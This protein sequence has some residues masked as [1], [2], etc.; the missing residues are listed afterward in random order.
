MPAA[1]TSPLVVV[2]GAGPAGAAAAHATASRGIRTILLERARHPREKVCGEGCTPRAVRNLER[3]G[4]LGSLES[5]GAQVSHAF[6]V[7]PG[8]IELHTPLPAR[9]HGGKALVVPRA[10]LDARLVDRAVRSGAELREQVRVES[11]QSHD[12]GIRVLCRGH[13]PIDADVVI[14]CDG[15]P[16]VV[17]KSLGAAAFSPRQH[18]FA[19]RG[20]F[21]NVDLRHPEAL[22]I[23]WDRRVLPAYGWVFPLPGGRANV[24]IGLRTDKLR[25]HDAGLP[26]IFDR[27]LDSPRLRTMLRH[28]RINGRAKGHGLPMTS[29]WGRVV[30]DRAILAG[31]AAGFVNPLTGEGIEY[32]LESGELAGEI[33]AAA[34]SRGDF[35]VA[36]LLPYA[37]MCKQRFG[38]VL[39]LNGWLRWAFTVPWLLDRMFRAGLRSR[40]VRDD[41]AA[42]AL[43]GDQARLTWRVASA[44]LLG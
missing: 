24:G 33:A 23:V 36:G 16:S 6:L 25:E 2:V 28:A 26:A 11:V 21:E 44:A 30:F 38:A 19:M 37:R 32:A 43:G 31:D 34:A 29:R 17:R 20:I 3:M 27:F 40:A 1:N 10:A 7:S 14:G 9:V 13:E 39:R 22:T 41:I 5:Q 8:G 42:I 4:L 35:S 15:M 18:A 12:R